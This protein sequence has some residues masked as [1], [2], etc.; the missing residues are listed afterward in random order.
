MATFKWVIPQDSMVT[1]KAIDN[2]TDVVVQVNAY[3]QITGD[4]S[5]TQIPVCVGLTPPTEGFVPYEDLTYE[6]VCGWLDAGTDTEALDAELTVQ[7][8]NIIN[9]PVAILPNPWDQTV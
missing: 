5:S 3:R 2:L 4:T 7:L 6:I 1:A 8:E 9:P